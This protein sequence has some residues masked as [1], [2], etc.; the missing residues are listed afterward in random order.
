MCESF[1]ATLECELIARTRFY[2]RSDAH[3][4]IRKY[5]EDFYN[6]RRIHSGIGYESP[7]NFEK[8]NHAA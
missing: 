8:L 1:F 5:I 7:A 2:S 4:Q 6:T 3:W